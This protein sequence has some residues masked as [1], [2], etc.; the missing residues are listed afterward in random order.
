MSYVS[1][2]RLPCILSAVVWAFILACG[3]YAEDAAKGGAMLGSMKADRIL[4]LGNSITLHAPWLPYG[5]K[6]HCGMAASVPAKDYVHVL[7]AGIDART[8]GHLV[9]NPP[10]LAKPGPD[11]AVILKDV[12]VLNIADIFERRYADYTS[13]RLQAQFDTKPDVVVLQF[14]ENMV[15]EAFNADAFKSALQRLMAGLK[16]SSNPNIFV[17]S[18][19]LRAGG[20]VDDIKRQVCAEDPSHRVFVDLSAFGQ[21]KTN[22]ASAETFYTGVVVGHPGDKGMGVIADAILKAM[23]VHGEAAPAADAKQ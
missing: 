9:L 15:M 1:F 7:A 22:F 13:A 16:E 10:D 14:G 6:S 17:T 12:N 21:D 4:V 2:L 11:G 20:A 23:V 18:E 3:C 8:G 19:L 5:W